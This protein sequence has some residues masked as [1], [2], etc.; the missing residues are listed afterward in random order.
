MESVGVPR[1]SSETHKV[2]AQLTR[3]HVFFQTR[4][5]SVEDVNALQGSSELDRSALPSV[6][7]T[8]ILLTETVSVKMA[9]RE[10]TVSVELVL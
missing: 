2:S 1:D 6:E 9:S 3:R 7:S 4:P 8:K 5:L 10:S